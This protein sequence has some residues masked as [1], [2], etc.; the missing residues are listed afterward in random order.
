M[1]WNGKLGLM[2][3]CADVITGQEMLHFIVSE[4]S[5]V[6]WPGSFQLH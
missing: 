1:G 6:Q 2:V 5:I 4:T 3:F